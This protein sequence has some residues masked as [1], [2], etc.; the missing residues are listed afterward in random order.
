MPLTIQEMAPQSTNLASVSTSLV[1]RETR[2][3]RLVSLCSATLSAWMW[4][5]TR[6]R[7]PYNVFSAAR[8]MR[9][10]VAR[11]MK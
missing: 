2:T 1:T 8:I 4:A 10:N 11:P 9:K 6:T 3:P 5:K 7:S